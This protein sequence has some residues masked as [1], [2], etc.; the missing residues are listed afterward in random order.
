MC[1]A[2]DVEVLGEKDGRSVGKCKACELIRTLV[3]PEDYSELYTVGDTYHAGREGHTPYRDRFDHDY[4]VAESRLRVLERFQNPRLLDVGCAN[5]A[6]VEAAWRW[7]YDSEGFELNPSIAGWAANKVH[8]PIHTSWDTVVGPF[9]VISLH[10][11]IE[12][13]PQPQQE[14]ERLRELLTWDGFLVVDTPDIGHWADDPMKSH[15]VKPQ[16]HLWLLAERHLTELLVRS[17][18]HKPRYD[19]PLPGKIVA[20]ARRAR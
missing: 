18:F 2:L 12:H 7:G 20:Y 16:E 13:M 10:D 19:R 5:G 6:F 1:G 17:G 11:V 3:V 4:G 15:H 9:D 14:L 8:R